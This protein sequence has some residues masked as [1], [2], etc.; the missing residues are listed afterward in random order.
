MHFSTMLFHFC[1]NCSSQTSIICAVRHK[2]RTARFQI[3]TKLTDWTDCS[4]CQC[5][6]RR[7]HAM[8]IGISTGMNCFQ[9]SFCFI[10]KRKEF[11][12]DSGGSNCKLFDSWKFA[13]LLPANLMSHDILLVH[14]IPWID[15]WFIT[16]HYKNY[17]IA[18][19]NDVN[20]CN[21]NFLSNTVNFEADQAFVDFAVLYKCDTEAL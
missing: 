16:E 21:F 14:C 11:W 4:S 20:D 6:Q 17:I 13:L 8:H 18:H 7:H 19:C 1:K 10:G 9:L 12:S 2:R 5:E 3:L 15:Y